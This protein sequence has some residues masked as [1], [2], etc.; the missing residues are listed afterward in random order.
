NLVMKGNDALKEVLTNTNVVQILDI[1][2]VSVQTY[3]KVLT[4]QNP[5]PNALLYQNGFIHSELA[6]GYFRRATS[7]QEEYI[8]P[9]GS[10]QLSNTYR[11]LAITPSIQ[12]TQ[13]FA[14]RLASLDPSFEDATPLISG[15]EGPFPLESF[16]EP[17]SEINEN[18]YF[19][20]FG[21]D[22]PAAVISIYHFE[23]DGEFTAA[24]N[25]NPRTM[26]WEKV[27]NSG[28]DE[29]NI[30]SFNAPDRVIKLN[31]SDLLSEAVNISST[32]DLF[33]TQLITPNQDLK[34]DEFYI[35][36]ADKRDNDHIKIFN[37]WGANVYESDNYQNDWDGVADKGFIPL[38]EES[39]YGLRVPPGAYF[40]EYQPNA[41]SDFVLSGYFHVH[42]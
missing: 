41:D 5:D 15:L 27:L 10:Y 26:Q 7:A 8:F 37:R 2:N 32:S 42:Y 23:T 24:A 22:D 35:E 18:F 13:Y 30:S 17:L 25:W 34:N 6:G 12:D 38:K 20:I 16:N 4:L 1:E 11:P 28:T 31:K 40:F 19:N 14:V 36:G 9:L 21:Q 39:E 29:S 3:D 33:Y